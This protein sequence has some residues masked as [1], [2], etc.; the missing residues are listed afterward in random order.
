M[1]QQ[2]MANYD[3]DVALVT[4]ALDSTVPENKSGGGAVVQFFGDVRPLENGEPIDGIEY[5]AHWEMAEYQLRNIVDAAAQRFGLLGV[6]LRHRVGFVGAGETSLLV[7]VTAAHRDAAFD[8]S[9]WIIDG[10]KQRV[11]IWKSVRR[12]VRSKRTESTPALV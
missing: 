8:A 7:R 12:Q 1:V 2:R 6:H 9:R 3:C 11:P 5:E 10:L 4:D